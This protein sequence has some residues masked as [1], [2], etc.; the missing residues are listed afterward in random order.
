MS[1]TVEFLTTA[2]EELA[3]LP[4]EAQRQILK[5]IEGLSSDPRLAGIK[6]LAGPEKFLRLRAGNY[7][8]IYLIEGKKL[9]VLIVRVA[10][11]KDAYEDL[12]PITRRV[13]AWRQSK[14]SGAR[15]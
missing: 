10:D 11:R 8:I 5:R 9:V 4:K 13:T 1:Y 14:K 3:A 7:R 6:Q 2:E 15:K 12:Q